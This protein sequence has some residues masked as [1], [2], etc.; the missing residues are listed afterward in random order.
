M[1][2][3]SLK[4]PFLFGLAAILTLL[5]VAPLIWVALSSFKTRIEIFSTPPVWLPEE[6][7]FQNYADLFRFNVPYLINSLVV[8]SISTLGVLLLSVPAAFGLTAFN[9]R[10]KHDLEMWFL[11]GRMM[12]PV[13]AAIPFYLTLRQI[14]LIDT[15][16]GLILLY[17]AVGIPLAVWLITSFMRS[18]HPAIYEAAQIDGCKWREIFLRIAVPLSSGGIATATIFITIFAWNELLLPLFLTNRFAKTF[19]VVL[20]SFQGQTEIAWELMCAGATIQVL[21][22][23]ILTFFVQRYIVSGLTLGSV[24]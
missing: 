19:P 8:T 12:P 23:V 4:K 15:Q 20:T 11:S 17:M 13:A 7:Q 22:I 21:P 16:I 10:K 1:R 9:F 2:K 5:N 24:K 3:R 14:K 6:W 18:I